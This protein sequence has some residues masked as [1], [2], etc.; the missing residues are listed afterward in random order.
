MLDR[1]AQLMPY[2]QERSTA[3]MG[4]MLVEALAYVADHLSYQQDV[5]ATESYLS[6]ARRRVS[7][8]RHAR[9][10]DY[11]TNEGCNARTWIQV[12]VNKDVVS[13]TVD[14]PILA[15]EDIKF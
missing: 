1:L 9:L 4:V 8:R 6:T 3:D 13:S 15:K 14:T 12:Q 10:L 11:L 5:I 2:W 7:A